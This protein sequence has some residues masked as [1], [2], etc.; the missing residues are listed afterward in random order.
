MKGQGDGPTLN[1]VLV[2]SGKVKCEFKGWGKIRGGR[3]VEGKGAWVLV[4]E[5]QDLGAALL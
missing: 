3:G 2:L 5:G 4:A 1:K